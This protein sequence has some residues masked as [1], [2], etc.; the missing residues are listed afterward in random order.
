MTAFSPPKF[1]VK[2]FRLKKNQVPL[3][4]LS[5]PNGMKAGA[6]YSFDFPNSPS[7]LQL[8][9]KTMRPPKII[10][11]IFAAMA[12][13]KPRIS[14]RFGQDHQDG[15]AKTDPPMDPIPPKMTILKIRK[16]SWTTKAGWVDKGDVMGIEDARYAGKESCDN[17]GQ[18]LESGDVFS[19]CQCSDVVLTDGLENFSKS[20]TSKPPAYRKS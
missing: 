19:D 5:A 14:E 18:N 10:C 11:R 2:F 4:P 3:R 8:M 1:F 15:R 12:L 6:F 7:G 20:R 13:G 9:M 17:K 16:D